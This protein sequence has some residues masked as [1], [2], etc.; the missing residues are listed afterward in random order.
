M[1]WSIDPTKFIDS[2]DMSVRRW[3]MEVSTDMYRSLVNK[4][5]VDTGRFRASWNMTSGTPVFLDIDTGGVSGAPLPAPRVPKV[6]GVGKY[7]TI[8]ITNGRRYG[9]ALENG[10]SSQAPLGMVAVTL[11]EYGF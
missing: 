6:L 3:T 2:V 11:A 5:P 4:S 10:H 7:P 1:Y 8:H 9:A